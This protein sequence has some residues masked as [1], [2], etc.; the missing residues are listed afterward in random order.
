[1]GVLVGLG[2]AVAVARLTGMAVWVFVLMGTRVKVTVLVLVGREVE[3]GV[4][5]DSGTSVAG[6]V[7]FGLVVFVGVGITVWVG[8][9]ILAGIK[10]LKVTPTELFPVVATIAIRFAVTSRCGISRPASTF[11]GQSVS[12][13]RTSTASNPKL[14][15]RIIALFIQAPFR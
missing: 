5:V 11:N 3:D 4:S 9:L 12:A 6:P 8:V 14:A 1:M 10:A 15:N 7:G 13:A 2:V